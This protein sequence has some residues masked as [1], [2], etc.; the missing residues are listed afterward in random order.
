MWYL[1]IHQGSNTNWQQFDIA[2]MTNFEEDETPGT[3]LMSIS[4]IR[5]ESK[6]KINDFKKILLTLLNKIPPL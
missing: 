5:V 2:F 4:S 6:E 3:L 1:G